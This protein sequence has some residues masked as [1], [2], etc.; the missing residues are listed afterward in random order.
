MKMLNIGYGDEVITVSNSWISSSETITQTGAKPVFVDCDPDFYTI[1]TNL[2]E[3][4]ITSKTKAI[5]PVHLY[6]QMADMDKI[7][8]ISSDYNLFVIEDCAQSHFLN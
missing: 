1:D 8:K 3:N 5:I 7:L 2:I 6:G 4:K